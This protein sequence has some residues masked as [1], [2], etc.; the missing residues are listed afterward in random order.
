MLQN[1]SLYGILFDKL[2]KILKP[3]NCFSNVLF[4]SFHAEGFGCTNV[5]ALL[6]KLNGKKMQY[7]VLNDTILK[8]Q[9]IQLVFIG[10]NLEKSSTRDLQLP[11]PLYTETLSIFPTA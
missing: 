9:I 5:L 10:I 1:T 6:R 11:L 4:L 8:V 2:H 7:T 3:F